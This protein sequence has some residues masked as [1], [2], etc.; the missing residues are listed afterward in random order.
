MPYKTQYFTI[1]LPS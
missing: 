1:I